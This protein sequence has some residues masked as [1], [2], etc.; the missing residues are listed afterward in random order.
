MTALSQTDERKINH[1]SSSDPQWLNSP[2]Y[3]QVQ[4]NTYDINAEEIELIAK[5]YLSIIKM[6]AIQFANNLNRMKKIQFVEEWDILVKEMKANHDSV[7]QNHPGAQVAPFQTW[8]DA[9]LE[10][11]NFVT[12][13]IQPLLA[14]IIGDT[15]Y[16]RAADIK[17]RSDIMEQGSQIFL[18]HVAEFEKIM[19]K[20]LP[21]GSGAVV[22]AAKY[23][24][25]YD[26]SRNDIIEELRECFAESYYDT[27]GDTVA[28]VD[29][30]F[31]KLM[32]R[33][34]DLWDVGTWA[35][36]W[37]RYKG[38]IPKT[39]ADMQTYLK[40]LPSSSAAAQMEYYD[41]YYDDNWYKSQ[42]FY[43][44]SLPTP[45]INGPTPNN[46]LRFV[47][48]NDLIQY[49]Y[50]PMMII[51]AV[52]LIILFSIIMC[53]LSAFCGLIGGYLIQQRKSSKS[54]IYELVD[55]SHV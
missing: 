1:A 52:L 40:A 19:M 5:K 46:D 33:N 48:N 32:K 2:C 45:N 37:V 50:D 3:S 22:K 30:M 26:Q 51:F 25:S 53:V 29:L 28:T 20:N 55:D 47:R 21:W 4:Q 54:R 34:P 10:D 31:K 7:M 16:L 18:T 13:H 6:D 41:E 49:G 23:A 44:D 43:L 27:Q 36:S 14:E 24:P 42:D 11:D 8:W 9:K 17:K 15:A 38:V 12:N 35:Y 39:V